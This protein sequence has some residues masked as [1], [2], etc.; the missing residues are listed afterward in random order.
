MRNPLL[1]L[2]NRSKFPVVFCVGLIVLFGSCKKEKNN[3]P[4]P[5]SKEV[6]I[7]Y[8]VSLANPT[9]KSTLNVLFT[10]NDKAWTIIPEII[11]PFSKQFTRTVK[12]GDGIKFEGFITDGGNV[13]LEL[14]VDGKVVYSETCYNRSFLKDEPKD[15]YTFQ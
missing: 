14:L 8:R 13:N 1:L 9:V 15:V 11:P 7:E 3:T 4:A 12:K 2:A 10:P 6:N 5:A